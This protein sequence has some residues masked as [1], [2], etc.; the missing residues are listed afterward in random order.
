MKIKTDNYADE[1][2]INFYNENS[3]S[4]SN[5]TLDLQLTEQWNAFSHLMNKGGSILDIGCG[6][7]RDMIKF[8]SLGFTT[9]GLEPSPLMAKIARKN[10]NS[11]VHEIPVE[12]LSTIERYDGIWACASLLHVHKNHISHSIENIL[13]ALKND[14]L[15]Y[16]SLKTG[17]GQKRQSDD[18]L[19]TYY[20][21]TA[22]LSLLEK[23]KNIKIIRI[24]STQDAG[25]R[26]ENEWLNCILRK[27]EIK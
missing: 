1:K 24:W 26:T 21:K 9:E 15:L 8:Q 7:G 6:S 22:I 25:Q 4:Y 5:K 27:V 23:F 19:F 10:T 2:T 11:I 18:R 17:T 14:G 3:E 12:Q 16:F 13:R 20:D